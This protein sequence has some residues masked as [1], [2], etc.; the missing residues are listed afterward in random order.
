MWVAPAGEIV[1]QTAEPRAPGK[2]L[3]RALGGE[4]TPRPPVWLMRQA[5]RYL[6]EFREIRRRVPDFLARCYDP[7]IAEELTLQPLRRFQLD[8][9]ILFSDILVVPDALGCPVRFIEGEG[10]RLPEPVRS[11]ADVA[12]LDAGRL[13]AHLRPVYETVARLRRS[14][15]GDAALIGFAGAPW[16]VAAYMVEGG[17]SKEFHGARA[18]ARREPAAFAALIDLLADAT[19]D[20]LLAQIEA[21]AE[22]VQLFDSWSGLLPEPEFERWCVAPVA[23]IAA[24]IKA[25]HPDLPVIAFPRGAGVLYRRLAALEAVDA[26]GLDTTVPLDWAVQAL[27]PPARCLAGNL[28]AGALRGGG[29]GRRVAAAR[30]ARTPGRG[31]RPFV[32]NLGHGVLPETDPAHV[33]A[34]VDHLRALPPPPPLT[35]ERTE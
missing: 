5:G 23:A 17:G 31:G 20:H 15:P 28:A 22:A 26:V 32:F 10:P 7:D 25:S 24:R 14:L 3:L 29:A 16:T 13:R 18:F 30:P 6:P 35:R 34:L 19:A 33:A 2:P 8:A 11:A 12:R 4:S 21:G 27:R 9:A 1:S